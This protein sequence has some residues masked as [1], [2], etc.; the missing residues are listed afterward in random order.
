MKLILAE[1]RAVR[2]TI[3]TFGEY[4]GDMSAKLAIGLMIAGGI[5]VVYF[6]WARII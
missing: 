5:A 1:G 6:L 4:P 2:P 3:C